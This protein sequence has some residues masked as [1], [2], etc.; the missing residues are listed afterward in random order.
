MKKLHF[1]GIGGAGMAPLAELAL[2]RNYTVSGSDEI[3]SAKCRH[4][5]AAGAVINIGHHEDNLPD[6]A[7]LLIYSSAVPENNCERLRA[8]ALGIPEMRRGEFLASFASGYK[9]CVS[10]SG[11]H[12]KSSITAALVSILRCCG[13]DPGFLI[14]AEVAGMPSCAAGDGDI[15]VTEADESDGTHTLMKNFL[16]VIPNIED[17]HEWSLGGKTVLENNFRQMAA[18]SEKII[19]YASEKCDE[20]LTFHS[21]R[22][23]LAQIPEKFGKLCGFQAANAFIAA[24][25]AIILGCDPQSALPAAEQYPQVA[26]RMTVHKQ[27]PRYTVI[28]DYAHHP[29]EVSA[30]LSLLRHNYP[31]RHLRV[32]FQPHRFARLE[33]Y[34]AEFVE[35][36]RSADSVFIAPVFAAWS[37]TGSVDAEVLANAV[38]G[39]AVSGDCV[40]WAEIVR[41]DLPDNSVIAVLGAGDVNKVI[42][43]L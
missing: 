16:A 37:E 23:R 43:Q 2:A 34:F 3:D 19:Y 24:Q 42:A 31:G 13:K 4:L 33:K 8:K 25:A 1:T 26:R 35:V 10:V 41:H 15:F 20:L 28:E 27:T 39:I 14:G 29:T 5:A 18:N 22:H 9:C 17:D 40:Q 11:T 6:D 38:N 21:D 36:L 12:G 7:E 30:A 32:L